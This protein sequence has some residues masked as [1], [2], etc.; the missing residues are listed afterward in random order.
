MTVNAMKF[1]I[2]ETHIYLRT[3]KQESSLSQDKKSTTDGCQFLG[4]RLISWQCKKQTIVATSTTDRHEYVAAAIIA[5][6]QVLWD[7]NQLLDYG[8]NFKNTKNHIDNESTICIV[9]NPVYHSKTKHIEIRHHFIRDC[10]EKKLISVEKIHTDFNVADLLTKPFDGPRFNYLVGFRRYEFLRSSNSRYALSTN[11]TIYDSLV[12]QF[13]QTATAN[14]IADGTLELHATIDTTEYTITEA[15]IRDK[16]HLADA[17]G[18]TM[19]PNNEIFEGMGQMGYPTDGSFT[20]WKSFF[21]PQWRFLVPPNF[22]CISSKSGGWGS[23]DSNNLRQMTLDDLLQVVPQLMTKIDSLEKELKQT[24][25]TMGSTI[26]K[27]VK[28]VKKMEGILKRR[29]VVFS[30]SNEEESGGSREEKSTMT[31]LVSLVQGL[32]NPSKTTINAFREEQTVFTS[33]NPSLINAKEQG[34]GAPWIIR[35][36]TF[37]ERRK[38]TQEHISKANEQDDSALEILGAMLKDITKDDLTD[39]IVGVYEKIGMDSLEDDL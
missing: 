11:P 25:L 2:G 16:L 34:K 5:V 28:K 3:Y 19:L 18:I 24:K 13:W 17:S 4:Q 8:F 10:Y 31:L 14:T 35:L 20:F 26:M 23:N 33:P 36:D 27:L 6:D 38:G 15:S 30:D 39:I 9:K 12:K 1:P 7:Q 32:V 22:V 37:G 21:T 29:N